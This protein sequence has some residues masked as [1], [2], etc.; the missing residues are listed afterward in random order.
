M[1]SEMMSTR[2]V[3]AYL[4]IKERK[5]YD[6]VRRRRIPCTRVTG[7]W[8]FPKTLVD[9]WINGTVEFA[10]MGASLAGPAPAVLAGSHDPLLEWALRESGSDLA[11]LSAG[12]LDGLRRLADGEAAMCGMH[13][14]DSETGE[15]NVPAVRQSSVAREVVVLEWAW[16]QQGLVVAPGNPKGLEGMADLARPELTVVQRQPEAGSQVLL[17]NLLQRARLSAADLNLLAP[18]ARSESDVALAVLEGKADAGV[19]I[20]CVAA[21]FRLGFV[22]L[23]RE[24]YDLVVRRRD[25]FEPPLQMLLQF[26]RSRPFERKAKELEGYDVSDLGRVVWNGD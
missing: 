10:P 23:V 6:L 12:S 24:R 22:P 20:A 2:E 8:L 21:Q 13:V 7:K 16:R 17:V 9:Q 1:T 5:V 18:P 26:A 4:G 3:A 19:A 15:Y 11:L 25:F 14:L